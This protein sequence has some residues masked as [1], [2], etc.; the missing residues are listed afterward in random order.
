[1]T[2]LPESSRVVANAAGALGYK[3]NRGALEAFGVQAI[4]W[5][6]DH[7]PRF[8]IRASLA[9]LNTASAS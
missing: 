6:I 1:M 2:C 9:S 3:E 5:S 8:E 7:T 4:V